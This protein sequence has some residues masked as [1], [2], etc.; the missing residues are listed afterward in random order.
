MRWLNR[1][2]TEAYEGSMR[3][4]L[5][6]LVGD[7]LKKQGFKA[8]Y[9]ARAGELDTKVP[10]TEMGIKSLGSNVIGGLITQAGTP[11]S[12]WLQFNAVV[13]VQYL[14]DQEAPACARYL[15]TYA[16][17]GRGRDIVPMGR[18][19]KTWILFPRGFALIDDSGHVFPGTEG[20]PVAHS[21][22]WGW[23]RFGEMLPADYI[24]T[25]G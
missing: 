19:Q 21:G 20:Y 7:R 18:N 25:D 23:V 6:A 17:S 13:M 12:R 10:I 24:P 22:Y 2:R 4:F 5:T 1:D 14:K 15:N 11:G 3:H 9:V 16:P 8:Y